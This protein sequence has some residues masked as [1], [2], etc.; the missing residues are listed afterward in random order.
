MSEEC[1][2]TDA[3]VAEY[4]T[5]A[6]DVNAKEL[7]EQLKSVLPEQ[8]SL[9]ELGSGPGTDWEILNETYQTTGSDNS[10]QFLAHL[11][12]RHP[13]G[14]FIELDAAKLETADK[15]DGIFSNKVLHHLTDQALAT[16]IER[17][18]KILN[19]KGIIC[20]S[21]WKGEG[22]EVFKGMFVNYHSI[23][24]IKEA[25]EQLFE[26]ITLERYQEFDADDSLLLIARLK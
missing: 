1:Y 2:H 11:A 14:K 22:S 21:F 7:I 20:H 6:K 16:S 17:Q 18:A 12:K 5:L 15:F 13:S 4:I 9:L 19:P 26:I 10:Q 25:F 24:D 8:A 3:S 23:A